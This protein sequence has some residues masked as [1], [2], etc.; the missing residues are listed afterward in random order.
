MGI[1]GRLGCRCDDFAGINILTR[2]LRSK[3]VIRK[4]DIDGDGDG[5]DGGD[6]WE[7]GESVGVR[8]RLVSIGNALSS[9]VKVQ[10]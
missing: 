5:G 4:R 8:S 1:D 3:W 2:H 9:S 7:S 6:G 10:V